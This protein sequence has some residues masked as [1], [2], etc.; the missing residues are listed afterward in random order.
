M[1]ERFHF[2]KNF[3]AEDFYRVLKNAACAVGNSSSFLREGAFLGTPSVGVGDRQNQREHSSNIIFS[4]YDRH[5]I[6]NKIREQLT[7]GPYAPNYLFGDGM[8]GAR[9]AEQIPLLKPNRLKPIT[10]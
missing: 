7:R 10:Y 4:S 3:S 5:D 6:S 9:I 2:Y 8:A 1:N